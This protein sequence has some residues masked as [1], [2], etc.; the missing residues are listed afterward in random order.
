[1]RSDVG[2]GEYA[3]ID[4]SAYSVGFHHGNRSVR[5]SSARK[6]ENEMKTAQKTHICA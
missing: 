2:E 1:M 4:A 3:W 5:P 6:D